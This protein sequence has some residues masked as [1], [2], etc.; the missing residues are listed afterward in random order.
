MAQINRRPSAFGQAYSICSRYSQRVERDVR[1]DDVGEASLTRKRQRDRS[2]ASA[3]VH[4]YPSRRVPGEIEDDV[5]ELLCLGARNE[6][7]LIDE[8]RE[9]S[10]CGTSCGVLDRHSRGAPL[11]GGKRTF[12]LAD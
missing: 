3:D 5:D 4:C 8:D 11:C 7:A 9:M 2:R 6:D 10:K 12:Q 1:P